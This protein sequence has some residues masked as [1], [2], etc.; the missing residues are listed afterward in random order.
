MYEVEKDP[1]D[2]REFQRTKGACELLCGGKIYELKDWSA[3]GCAVQGL[4]DMKEGDTAEV[5]LRVF[6]PRSS[7]TQVATAKVVRIDPDGV[8]LQFTD[9]KVEERDLLLIAQG[10]F[11]E[12][13]F[14][15]DLSEEQVI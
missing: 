11:S 4:N 10:A 1:A 7:L 6:G 12:N 2:R 9:L 3:G 13:V 8:A 14:V 15:M 5:T